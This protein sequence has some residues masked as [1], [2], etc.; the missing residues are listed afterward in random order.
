M[1]VKKAEIHFTNTTIKP[2]QLCEFSISR[3]YD[4]KL[5]AD[6]VPTDLVVDCSSS[7]MIVN[8]LRANGRDL[9]VSHSALPVGS[10]GRTALSQKP[11][12]AGSDF[13][14]GVTNLSEDPQTFTAVLLLEEKKSLADDVLSEMNEE[15]THGDLDPDRE[16]ESVAHEAPGIIGRCVDWFVRGIAA[17]IADRKLAQDK[18]DVPIGQMLSPARVRDSLR[19][20]VSDLVDVAEIPLE[21]SALYWKQIADLAHGSEPDRTP[22]AIPTTIGFGP[23]TIPAN[24]RSKVTINLVGAMQPRRLKFAPHCRVHELQIVDLMA[25]KDS[26]LLSTSPIPGSFGIAGIDI[27]TD[28]IAWTSVVL[29]IENTSRE[30]VDLSGVLE[31]D[32]MSFRSEQ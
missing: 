21:A 27:G 2:G 15:A 1:S 11:L 24:T 14:M 13:S 8:F 9:L 6:C 28:E 3:R 32:R 5:L 22:H 10:L 20:L 29:V 31:G 16:V 4:P 23:Q 17:A 19:R 30:E 12:N 26:L 25:G 18:G 7:N